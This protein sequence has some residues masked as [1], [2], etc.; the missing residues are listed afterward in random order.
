MG[1]TFNNVAKLG[2]VRVWRKFQADC[3]S[4]VL[5]E[6]FYKRI[7]EGFQVGYVVSRR[8]LVRDVWTRCVQLYSDEGREVGFPWAR[9]TSSFLTCLVSSPYLSYSSLS[10]V[11]QSCQSPHR[12]DST[13]YTISSRFRF[14]YLSF[15]AIHVLSSHQ[16]SSVVKN[17][18]VVYPFFYKQLTR[19]RVRNENTCDIV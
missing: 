13:A 3:K 19:A 18:P 6:P 2:R 7:K 16:Q 11:T 4:L 5:P 1:E 15:S 10:S 17:V 12:L 14:R 9:C 8:R